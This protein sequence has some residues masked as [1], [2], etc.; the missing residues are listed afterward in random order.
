M[1]ILKQADEI[2]N[3]RAEEKARQYGD[4]ADTMECMRDLFNL[5]TGCNCTAE[6]MYMA[7]VA[8]K[9]ARQ[10]H[11]HREDNLLDAVAY[12]GALNNY[13]NQTEQS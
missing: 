4:F 2:V 5:M 9:L 13:K 3:K 8:M 12:L 10:A 11:A 1:N 7:M 6:H